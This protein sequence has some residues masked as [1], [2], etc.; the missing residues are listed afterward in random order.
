M[1][2]P[3]DCPLN[4]LFLALSSANLKRLK[5]EL[6]QVLCEREQILLEADSEIE[7]VFFPDSAVISVVQVYEDGGMIET[8]TIGREGCT[9][10]EAFLGAKASS[11]RL[12]VQI[13]GRA[14]RMPRAAFSRAMASMPSL[15]NLMQSYVHAF[16]E[17]V[18]LSGAC[19][20]VHPL[21][22]RL[23]RWLLMMHDRID[24]DTLPITQ[25]LLAEVLGVQRPTITNAVRE[26][27][28]AGLIAPGRRQITIKNRAGLSHESCEC[29]HL[30]RARTGSHLPRTYE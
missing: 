17:Q 9:G 14:T 12:L 28:R 6:E 8:A 27:A 20:R 3:A 23:A 1:S 7:N 2:T 24:G 13:P 22:Q 10:F 30:I 25:S 4:R 19:N 15:R 11:A 5:P 21:K 16:L 18:L 29:Y 26:L